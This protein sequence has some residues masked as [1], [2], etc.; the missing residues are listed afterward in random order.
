[1]SAFEKRL[2]EAL[3]KYAPGRVKYVAGWRT[4]NTGRWRGRRHMPVMVMEH[5]TAGAAT[6][7][8]DANHKGNQPGANNGVVQYCVARNN[9]VPYC[10]A[11]IDRDGTIWILAAGPVWHAG[12]GDFTGTRWARWRIPKDSANSYTFGVEFISRGA[13]KD[14]TKQQIIASRR[15]N[16]ALREA[17][18]WSGFKYRIANHKDWAPGRKIDTRYDWQ[19]FRKGS[20][21]AWRRFRSAQS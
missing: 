9:P 19:W 13:R 16:C 21:I 1:M 11:V 2:Q 17:A 3:K 20:A 6:Q 8:R 18:M 10:N 14:F 12:R 5:H 7:S 15:L 4:R